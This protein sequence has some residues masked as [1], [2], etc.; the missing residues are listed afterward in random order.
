MMMN[1]SAAPASPVD[2][3]VHRPHSLE[4]LQAVLSA[5]DPPHY[6][7]AGGTDL[8]VMHKDGA[9][10]SSA[11]VDVTALEELRGIVLLGGHLRLGALATHEEVARSPLVRK[12][13]PA[14]AAACAL[15]GGPQ[16]RWRGTIGGNIANASPA[17]DAVPPLYTLGAEAE[18]LARDG[19]RRRVAIDAMFEGPRQAALADG[20]LVVA[21]RF[22]ARENVRGAFLRLGQRQ[23]QAISKVSVAVT[24]VMEGLKFQYLSIACGSVAPTVVAAPRTEAILREGGL[25]PSVVE[26]AVAEIGQE[27]RP[28]TDMRSTAEYRQAMAGVLLRRAMAQIARLWPLSGQGSHH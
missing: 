10:P 23:S 13:A 24:A 7:V 22:P 3:E 28:I 9:I 15:I 14:L 20:D 11:W 25:T 6:F 12:H 2:I 27:I 4:E 5:T 17:G 19:H 1:L 8:L 21:V 18:V 26:R 16:I